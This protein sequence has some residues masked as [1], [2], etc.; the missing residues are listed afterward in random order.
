MWQLDRTGAPPSWRDITEARAVLAF[1]TRLG[2]VSAPP[3]DTL[4]L[5]R[6]TDDR[7]DAVT[8][9]RRRL[10]AGIGLDPE[11]L[12]TAG[13]VHGADIREA[14][15]PGHLDRCDALVT[16]QP[17]LALAV[18]TADCMP[19]LL[20][21]RGAVA[22]VHAGWRGTAGGAPRVTLEALCR[23]AGTTPAEVE[24][25][26]GPCIRSCC[27]QV[28]SEVAGRFPATAVRRV[29]D[30][31]HLDLPVAAR[32]QLL[33]AGLAESAWHDTG[34]CTSCERELYFS[35]RRDEGRTG[36][37]WGVIAIPE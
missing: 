8:E 4:N 16:R 11:R 29:G 36:R 15:A 33:Q 7:P 25:H 30:V 17:G 34:G 14:L 21:A 26:L 9:N 23:I 3:F 32:D 22:A 37:H 13:Q 31:L 2:G 20:V 27:Y 18:T 10:L 24:V 12:A 35:H 19:L 6:S 1:S 5:G 28:G